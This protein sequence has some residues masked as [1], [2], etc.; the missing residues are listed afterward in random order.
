VPTSP[1]EHTA[2]VGQG[3]LAEAQ[4]LMDEAVELL[5]AGRFDEA[6]QVS[7]RAASLQVD[8]ERTLPALA[9]A[10]EAQGDLTAALEVYRQAMALRSD[11]PAISGDMGRLA[12]RMGKYDVAEDVLTLHIRM[13]PPGVEAIANLALAQAMLKAPHRANATLKAALEADPSQSLLWLTLAQVQC[14]DGRHAQAIVFFEEALRFDPASTRAQDG[15]A[16]ALLLG[17]GDVERALALSE[18]ALAGAAAD[19]V[20]TLTAAH[21]RRLLAAGRLEEGWEAFAKWMEPGDAAAVEMKIAAPLWTPG[22]PL[23]GRLLLVGEEGIADMILLAQVI[24]SIIADGAPLIFAFG[25]RLE[26]LARRSFP[27]A[28]TISLLN[29]EKAGK[30][31]QTADLDSP[32]VHRGELVAAWAPLRTMMRGYRARLADFA[33]AKPYL[34]V[35]GRRVD[36]WRECLAALGPGLKVG[37]VWRAPSGDRG[38]SWEAPPLLL[39]KEGLSVPGVHLIGVQEEELQ[40]ELGWIR[41]TIGLQIND[42]PP[43]LRHG[44]LDDLAALT[45]AMDVVIGPPDAAA[46][47][48]AACGAETWFLAPPRH[49]ALLGAGTYPWFPKAKVI[50]AAAPDDWSGAMAELQEALATFAGT[51]ASR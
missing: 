10:L 38:K 50:S 39:L 8:R 21:A 37:V 15:L 43:E 1:T 17:V 41:D 2:D 11:S 22:M 7:L 13:A 16:D 47:L 25:P 28:T 3:G 45:L 12:L 19:E 42:P 51:S 29:R 34:K 4:A 33:D 18:A 26:S 14:F 35:D 44:D 31:Q 49:W 6:V 32:H 48:A 46:C 5:Q 24:P 23:N 20:P 30:R 9:R 27:E 36:H 40:N